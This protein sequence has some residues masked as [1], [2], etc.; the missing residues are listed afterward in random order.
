[1]NSA[2]QCLSFK[3]LLLPFCIWIC[4]ILIYIP[5]NAQE[6]PPRPITVTVSTAQH[7]NFGTIIPTSA[8]GGT[9]TVDFDNTT[10]TF[11]DVLLLHSYDCRPALFIVDAEPGVLINI[12]C[13][14]NPTLSKGGFSLPLLLGTPYID[15]QPGYQFITTK[16]STSVYVGGKLTVGSLSANP[17]GDYNGLFS[18][19]F[20]QQ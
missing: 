11:G 12:V 6:N 7:L 16:K 2:Q 9:V 14:I 8:N 20:I 19:T 1:M 4:S 18:V 17:A 3:K 10:S 5:T 15:S 13:E